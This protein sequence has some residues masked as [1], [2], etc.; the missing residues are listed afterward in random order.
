MAGKR[1]KKIKVFIII[2]E[3][4]DREQVGIAFLCKYLPSE[5]CGVEADPVVQTVSL[6][7]GEYLT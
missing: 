1:W 2:V 5:S 6:F 4:W 7:K 3:I